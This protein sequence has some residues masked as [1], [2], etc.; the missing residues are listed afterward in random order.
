MAAFGLRHIGDYGAFVF[1]GALARHS[2][3]DGSAL[4]DALTKCDEDSWCH[5]MV[6]FNATMTTESMGTPHATMSHPWGA[7]PVGAIAHGVIGVRQSTAAWSEFVVQPRLATLRF[8]NLTLPT[9]RGAISVAAT[10]GRLSVDVP[11]NTR[12]T[13]CVM[14]PGDGAE[15]ARLLLDGESVP[16]VVSGRHICTASAVGCAAAPRVLV[17]V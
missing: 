4:L 6:A 12:A 16:F 8:A 14:P 10:P 11:C 9:I 13:L 5:E 3:D 1:T 2:F 15:P 7:S 17:L